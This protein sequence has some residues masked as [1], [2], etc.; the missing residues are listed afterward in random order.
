MN[1]SAGTHKKFPD[2][3]RHSGRCPSKMN[4]LTLT[5]YEDYIA[6]TLTKRPERVRFATTSSILLTDL[7]VLVGADLRFVELGTAVSI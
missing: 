4:N 3:S 7:T 2:V 1:F 6:G 5:D